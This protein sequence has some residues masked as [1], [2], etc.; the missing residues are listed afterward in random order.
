MHR[1]GTG[2]IRVAGVGRCKIVEGAEEWMRRDG[3][4]GTG[5]RGTGKRKGRDGWR[6]DGRM[7]GG[8]K[9]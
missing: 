7:G 6:R 8:R 1:R 5:M 9:D 3:R 2:E 4:G